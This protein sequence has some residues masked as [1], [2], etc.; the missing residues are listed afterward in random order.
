MARV[1]CSFAGQVRERGRATKSTLSHA[2]SER[3]S[4]LTDVWVDHC[5]RAIEA[6]YEGR[7]LA[8]EYC[9]QPNSYTY[10]GGVSVRVQWSVG[11]TYQVVHPPTCP[12]KNSQVD[13][14]ERIENENEDLCWKGR[15]TVGH[16]T[17][18][19][20]G[21][22]ARRFILEQGKYVWQEA[23]GAEINSEL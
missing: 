18:I 5:F 3:V 15:E 9:S 6:L 20:A 16:C 21:R 19:E 23:L 22:V 1:D 13:G 10:E 12:G 17:W 14:E 7:G 2:R 4:Y 11:M 8:R